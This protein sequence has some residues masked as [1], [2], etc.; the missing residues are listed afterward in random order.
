MIAPEEYRGNDY[1]EDDARCWVCSG[2]I[3]NNDPAKHM[4]DACADCKKYVD[5]MSRKEFYERE[6]QE[7]S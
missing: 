4:E 5:G 6:F 1:G 3:A 2:T 7:R